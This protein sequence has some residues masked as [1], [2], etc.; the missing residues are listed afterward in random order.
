MPAQREFVS[1]FSTEAVLSASTPVT[2][3]LVF[4][5]GQSESST[6]AEELLREGEVW[7]ETDGRDQTEVPT[8]PREAWFR[9]QRERCRSAAKTE[10]LNME[11][12]E[13]L[14]R[15]NGRKTCF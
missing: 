4:L 5:K 8:E 10:Q 3:A 9:Q 7:A 1:L 15:R 14:D 2:R 13:R 6:G 11:R 12:A